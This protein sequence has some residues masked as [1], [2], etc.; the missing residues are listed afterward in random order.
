MKFLQIN[1]K[2]TKQPIKKAKDMADVLQSNGR[3]EN[4]K[5]MNIISHQEMMTT[6]TVIHCLPST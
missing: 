5:I 3:L 4:E 1:S 2:K 6:A